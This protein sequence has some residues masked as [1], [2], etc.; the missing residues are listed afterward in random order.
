MYKKNPLL[1][2][3]LWT[4]GGVILLGGLLLWWMWPKTYDRLAEWQSFNHRRVARWFTIP[5]EARILRAEEYRNP[6]MGG[7]FLIEFRLPQTKEPNEWLKLVAP[8]ELRSQKVSRYRYDASHT[9][10][11]IYWLEYRP[12]SDLYAARWYWD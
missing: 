4:A 12:A 9:L 10:T 5:A 11:D 7:G 3:A 2:A 1:Y 8:K 6:I